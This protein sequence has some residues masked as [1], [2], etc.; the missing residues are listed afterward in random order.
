[1]TFDII[2]GLIL[3]G[4]II[5]GLRKGFFHEL[6]G[7]VGVFG[8]VLAGIL[9][10]GA[11]ARPFSKALPDFFA[12]E[13]FAL[14]LC[15]IALFLAIY[16]LSRLMARLFESLSEKIYLTWL[17]HLLGGFLA[18]IKGAF[19]LSLV[20]MFISFLPLQ[21]QLTPYQK[22][23][24]FHKPLYNLVPALYK[25]LGS[26]DELP[27][28]V[29]DILKKSRDKFLEDATKELKKDIKDAID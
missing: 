16:F 22:D 3:A 21:K 19:I 1:M 2:V 29:R 14:I 26:P 15:F 18:G 8:G 24:F 28:P 4:Y 17:N 23:S 7:F 25:Y 11:L 27:D 9:G 5:Y 12:K 13:I 6:F 20:F 10:A